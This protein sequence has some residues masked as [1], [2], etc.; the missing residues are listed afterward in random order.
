MAISS[1]ILLKILGIVYPTNIINRQP[2]DTAWIQC[3]ARDRKGKSDAELI[4]FTVIR[5]SLYGGEVI[6]TT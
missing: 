5:D 3:F 2:I 6:W 1:I 4:L